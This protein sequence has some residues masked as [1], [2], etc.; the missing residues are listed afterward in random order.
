MANNSEGIMA[1][2]KKYLTN[3]QKKKL[4]SLYA[5]YQ[6]TTAD[7][8]R[9]AYLQARK[10]A[11]RSAAAA[12]SMGLGGGYEARRQAAADAELDKYGLQ[13][14]RQADAAFESN[15]VVPMAN[16]T[17][18]AQNE[19][20]RKAYERK[21]KAAQRAYQDALNRQA[22]QQ[23]ARLTK[24]ERDRLKYYRYGQQYMDDALM[25]N[26]TAPHNAPKT[27]QTTNPRNHT[28][29]RDKAYQYAQEW[30]DEAGATRPKTKRERDRAKANR[31][32]QDWAGNAP[33]ESP[34]KKNN[35]SA[36][37]P[38]FDISPKQP[39]VLPPKY[40][41]EVEARVKDIAPN[42]VPQVKLDYLNE[43]NQYA[44]LLQGLNEAYK[45]VGKMQ[46]L[47]NQYQQLVRDISDPTLSVAQRKQ[48]SVLAQQLEQ[49]YR[50]AYNSFNANKAGLQYLQNRVEK[51]YGTLQIDRAVL[52]RLGVEMTEDDIGFNTGW[53][54]THGY[55][56]E[57]PEELFIATRD[58]IDNE[59]KTTDEFWKRAK[60]NSAVLFGYGDENGN[61]KNALGESTIPER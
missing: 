44:N 7:E 15:A 25:P 9:E 16:Q 33:K 50:E 43:V 12:S 46:D 45:P 54:K 55:I 8:R 60:N 4:R 37:N 28:H 18:K 36:V 38:K 21:R 52:G 13:L 6:Q 29:N 59:T 58:L 23:T 39:V 11:D 47:A 20:A 24:Q 22:Q 42:D 41:I 26:V 51:A 27:T 32:A 31:Y 61:Y 14:N 19:A 30:V 5:G 3:Q 40:A 57:T 17:I 2:Y 10:A 35:G 34:L 49:E 56:P 53:A 48:A 1:R